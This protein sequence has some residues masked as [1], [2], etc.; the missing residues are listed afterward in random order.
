MSVISFFNI[1]A[2]NLIEFMLFMC[3]TA[4]FLRF[5]AFK[6]NRQNKAFFNTLSH[7]MI[8]I[9][10]K[11]EKKGEPIE[12]ID[13]WFEEFLHEVESHMPEKSIRVKSLHRLKHRI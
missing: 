10:E 11:D 9:I 2:G 6:T 13:I 12:D 5:V 7:S 8:R 4:L 1:F 3:V